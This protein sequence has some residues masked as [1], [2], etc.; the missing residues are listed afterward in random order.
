[1][2]IYAGGTVGVG[3]QGIERLNYMIERNYNDIEGN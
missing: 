2:I 3:K 1:M